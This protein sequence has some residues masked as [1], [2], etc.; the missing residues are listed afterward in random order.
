[1]SK[2]KHDYQKIVSERFGNISETNLVVTVLSMHVRE[3]PLIFGS[4]PVPEV[5]SKQSPHYAAVSL[6]CLMGSGYRAVT[7]VTTHQDLNPIEGIN[8]EL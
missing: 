6:Q 2:T 1:M 5:I 8:Y 4:S 7:V 3:Y